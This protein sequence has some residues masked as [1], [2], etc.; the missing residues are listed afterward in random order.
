MLLRDFPRRT[1]G[2]PQSSFDMRRVLD[3]GILLARLPK[4][5]IGEE[6]S[7]LMG[8]F[9]LA[10]AWQAATGRIRLPE[11]DRR[12]ACAYVDEA[13][14]FLRWRTR[15]RLLY[16]HAD[17]NTLTL[18]AT[19]G[20][21][22]ASVPLSGAVSDGWCAL[23]P[24]TVIKALT[25]IKPAGKSAQTATVTLHGEADRLYL[26][27][28]DGP[29]V[30]LD[31]DTPQG[32]PATV[33]ARPEPHEQPLT[34]GPV[35][36]WCDL[37]G[38]VA[39]AA[40][41]EATRP[42][43]AVVRLLRDHPQVVLM[44]EATD[45]YRIHRGTWADPHGEPV[46]VPMPA[47]AARR[48]VRLLHTLDPAGQVRVHTDDSHVVWRTDRVRLA[49]K[50][51]GRTFPNL[52][53]IREDVLDDA[54]STFSVNRIALVAAL[55]TAHD[56]PIGPGSPASRHPWTARVDQRARGP[57]TH[58]D[59]LPSRAATTRCAANPTCGRS[60][61]GAPSAAEPATQSCPPE[62]RR[63]TSGDRV[64]TRPSR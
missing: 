37:V 7:R 3:G 11:P 5:Q 54:T 15:T 40:G 59:P 1:F 21:E 16:L 31:T 51:G 9:V 41:R 2:A 17:G 4:G 49:A 61:G 24:D 62:R 27:V 10:S 36:D 35:A 60:H 46:D 18:S 19:T 13:H 50:N 38:G 28:G 6:T 8:S 53:K 63:A 56:L 34:C 20:D 26:S 47:D 42:D 64:R 33:A 29:A 30:G 57:T 14:N 43:L 58:D 22:T 44:V 32:D 55:N 52:E 45:A 48:A 39:T 25:A 23:P 12:D